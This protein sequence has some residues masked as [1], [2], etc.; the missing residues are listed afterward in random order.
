[1]PPKTSISSALS[2]RCP[3]CTVRTFASSSKLLAVGPEHPRYVKVP[4]PPQQTVP[5]NPPVKGTLPI[6]RNVF[7]GNSK[8]RSD[9]EI[10]ALST[11]SPKN[12]KN[13]PKG[14]REEWK[15]KMS[16][17][18]KQNLREGVKSLRAR[19]IS[20]ERH[21]NVRQAAKQRERQEL[22]QRPDRED[23]RLTAPSNNM[24]LDALYNK[25]IPDPTRED[26]IRTKQLNLQRHEDMKRQ[27]RMEAV[28]SLYMNAREFIVTPQQLDKAVDA[29]FGTPEM[30]VQFGKFSTGVSNRSIWAEGRPERVQDKLNVANGQA[31]GFAM[32]SAK[33]SSEINKERIR[34]IAETFTGGKIEKSV[35]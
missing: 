8:G 14:S 19:Q 22:L 21:Q 9:D 7:A 20:D 31:T 6:P 28:H 2:W 34:R 23:E 12:P 33:S 32:R 35:E 3:Q 29:A 15:A 1:M 17:I 5:H 30:P 24:D 11:P 4:E 13:P 27:E 18:R 10:I 16:E 26:R 25:P